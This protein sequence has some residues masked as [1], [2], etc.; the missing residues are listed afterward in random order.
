MT[1]G[2]TA[3]GNEFEHPFGGKA[4]ERLAYGAAADA[5]I[6]GQLAGDQP[7]AGNVAALEDSLAQRCDHHVHALAPALAGER[8]EVGGEAL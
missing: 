7:L 8:I 1:D 5:E 6:L 4:A 2:G 3:V